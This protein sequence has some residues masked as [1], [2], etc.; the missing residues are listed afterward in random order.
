MKTWIQ[1]R[2]YDS[3]GIYWI[4]YGDHKPNWQKDEGGMFVTGKM[5]CQLFKMI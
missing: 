1:H 5:L 4:W 2:P 3:I